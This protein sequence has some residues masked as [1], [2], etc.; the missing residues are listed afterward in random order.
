MQ[1]FNA[2]VLIS[3][4]DDDKHR[5][6]HTRCISTR[7]SKRVSVQYS[8]LWRPVSTALCQAH[9]EMAAQLQ[10]DDVTGFRLLMTSLLGFKSL[11]F[12]FTCKFFNSLEP[13]LQLHFNRYI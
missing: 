9:F 10:R 3:L 11:W 6:L 12:G 13:K 7:Q 1:V 5:I 4:F 8:C 2:A